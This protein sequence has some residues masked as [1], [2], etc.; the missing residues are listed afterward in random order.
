MGA[1]RPTRLLRTC[2]EVRD[3]GERPIPEDVLLGILEVARWTGPS[4]NSQPWE[5]V[6]VGDR[7]TLARLAAVVPD[8]EQVAQAPLT[9]VQ[10]TTSA[11]RVGDLGRQA[12][13]IMLAARSHGIGSR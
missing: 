7:E 3:Y 11:E 10:V 5:L 4:K 12:E 6:V 1:T 13:R 8:A 9:V 2:Q